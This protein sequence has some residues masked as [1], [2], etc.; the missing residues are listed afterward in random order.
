MLTQT[1]LDKLA[2]MQD[3]LNQMV[4]VSAG[5]KGSWKEQDWDFGLAIIDECMELHGHLGWKWW[6][7]SSL[8]HAGVTPANKKQVQLE[9]IDILHFGLSMLIKEDA[10]YNAAYWDSH[11]NDTIQYR[12]RNLMQDAIAYF[13]NLPDWEALATHVDLTADD[14]MEVY[15]GKYALNKF[16]QDNGYADGSYKKNWL[17][18]EFSA[19][20]EEDNWYLERSI[21][22]LKDA[23]QEVTAERITL[24]LDSYY[25]LME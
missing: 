16:R 18:P 24:H 19:K 14:V 2:A 22:Q 15:T 5:F 20:F 12:I 4:C 25:S 11:F 3:E 7:D 13:F 1:Q 6:K 17:I 9:V 23:G 21:K 10:V 8:Y